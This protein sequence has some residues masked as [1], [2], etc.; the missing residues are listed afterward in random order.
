MGLWAKPMMHHMHGQEME[1]MS[2]NIFMAKCFW[3][4]VECLKTTHD[5]KILA[6]SNVT[7]VFLLVLIVFNALWRVSLTLWN[8]F[9]IFFCVFFSF[10]LGNS[11]VCRTFVQT[12]LLPHATSFPWVVAKELRE[13]CCLRQIK[14]GRCG[15]MSHQSEQVLYLVCPMPCLNPVHVYGCLKRDCID[16]KSVV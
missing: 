10:S 9:D 3:R 14:V 2:H 5:L 4:V 15:I 13:L 7:L 1:M 6:L 8:T 12:W 11:C 16:R